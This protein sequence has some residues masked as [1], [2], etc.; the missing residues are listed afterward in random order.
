MIDGTCNAPLAEAFQLFKVLTKSR[1]VSNLIDRISDRIHQYPTSNSSQIPTEDSYWHKKPQPRIH[2]WML[3]ALATVL[4]TVLVTVLD[5]F[6]ISATP[7]EPT[8]IDPCAAQV[9]PDVPDPQMHCR[10]PIA[11]TRDT[12]KIS[13]LENPSLANGFIDKNLNYFVSASELLHILHHSS[14]TSDTDSNSSGRPD[15]NLLS[16]LPREVTV[17]NTWLG[18]SRRIPTSWPRSGRSW[19]LHPEVQNQNIL[20]F[21]HLQT[22]TV[23]ALQTLVNKSEIAWQSW[24]QMHRISSN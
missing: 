11:K 19:S 5:C 10:M 1:S 15:I 22:L 24:C 4:V 17:A 6:L 3:G 9:V 13:K 7:D 23:K 20:H 21:K 8:H 12:R 16:C 14:R 2:F 18:P